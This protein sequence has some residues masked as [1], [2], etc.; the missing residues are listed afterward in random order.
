[1]I[2]HAIYNVYTYHKKYC[3]QK[4]HNVGEYVV[5]KYGGGN[6]KIIESRTGFIIDGKVLRETPETKSTIDALNA[7]VASSQSSPDANMRITPGITITTKRSD[8]SKPDRRIL[9]SYIYVGEMVNDALEPIG[10]PRT[11]VQDQIESA[12]VFSP[13]PL[14]RE[15][16]ASAMLPPSVVEQQQSLLMDKLNALTTKFITNLKTLPDTQ[17]EAFIK[18]IARWFKNIEGHERTS[19]RLIGCLTAV[20]KNEH[21]DQNVKCIM[22]IMFPQTDV[23]ETTFQEELFKFPQWFEPVAMDKREFYNQKLD[24]LLRVLVAIYET[25]VQINGLRGGRPHFK[26]HKR[27]RHKRSRHK[28]TN[29]TKRTKNN[30]RRR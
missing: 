10:P 7:A 23:V 17:R 26:K 3:M 20:I 27:S 21:V 16:F 6:A 15:A 24:D 13:S 29:R 2:L 19:S 4:H 9:Y 25:I 8:P 14:M 11:F 30:K 22:R 12:I 1:M 18:G 28:R 5:L